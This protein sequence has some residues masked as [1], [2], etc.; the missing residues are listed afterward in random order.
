MLCI[1]SK[2]MEKEVLKPSQATLLPS[3]NCWTHVSG[4][5]GKKWSMELLLIQ[6]T[7][8]W[9]RKVRKNE[10]RNSFK[11]ESLIEIATVT[12]LSTFISYHSVHSDHNDQ[13]ETGLNWHCC[14]QSSLHHQIC[15]PQFWALCGRC[16]PPNFL[17]GIPHWRG[18]D[19]SLQV[20]ATPTATIETKACRSHRRFTSVVN[21]LTL[22]WLPVHHHGVGVMR[23]GKR[24]SRCAPGICFRPSLT[25][26]FMMTCG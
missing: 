20:S 25:Y 8:T 9:Q 5:I 14:K 24:V 15:F 2:L 19:P 16:A 17:V 18:L 4:P 6:L 3:L 21:R 22:K 12:E 23:K 7:E 10:K 1:T 13:M 11:N 26:T